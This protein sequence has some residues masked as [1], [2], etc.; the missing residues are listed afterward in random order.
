MSPLRSGRNKKRVGERE[1]SL[2]D[3]AFPVLHC[4]DSSSV[5]I[6]PR[7]TQNL[8]MAIK[9]RP[10]KCLNLKKLKYTFYTL[11][12]VFRRTDIEVSKSGTRIQSNANVTLTPLNG[13]TC[14]TRA[15]LVQI[16][17]ITLL[18]CECDVMAGKKILGFSLKWVVALR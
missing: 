8:N 6:T 9:Q 3:F 17:E 5:F 15:Y 2:H 16:L 13:N 10:W 18:F 1:E 7:I 4:T 14:I 12:R 11:M